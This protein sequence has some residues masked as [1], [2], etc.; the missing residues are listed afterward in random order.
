M[1]A[2]H[3]PW[4][5]FL[6]VPTLLAPQHCSSSN[7]ASSI[8]ALL[9]ACSLMQ[10]LAKGLANRSFKLVSGGTDNHIVLADVRSKVRSNEPAN[11]P[12]RQPSGCN[13][14]PDFIPAKFTARCP[15]SK[16]IPRSSPALVLPTL[17]HTTPTPTYP[18]PLCRGPLR[19]AAGC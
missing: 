11:T 2:S 1:C 10:A 17:F 4:L 16:P 8:G 9:P 12:P 14:L 19:L 13:H 6:R 15:D 7:C 18:Y 3:M 5:A